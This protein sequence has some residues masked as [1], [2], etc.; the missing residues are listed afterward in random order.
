[1]TGLTVYVRRLTG[2]VITYELDLDATGA[3][4]LE[5]SGCSVL[6]FG[7]Q[8]VN[9]RELL[10][11]QDFSNGTEVA[12]VVTSTI[13]K[14]KVWNNY[15]YVVISGDRRWVKEFLVI[16][17][18]GWCRGIVYRLT[19]KTIMRSE[20]QAPYCT[21][22]IGWFRGECWYKYDG[23]GR[24]LKVERRG[25]GYTTETFPGEEVSNFPAT[26]PA[27]AFTPDEL[28]LFPGIK[29]PIP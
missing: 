24:I 13:Y 29:F 1:M 20:E 9:P 22:D 25:Y 19:E 7:E 15:V 18:W 11:E 16:G 8:I 4:L 27:D 23:P 5:A 3:D 6:Q 14:V 10:S 26:F 21:V 17:T 28:K 12:E 2:E